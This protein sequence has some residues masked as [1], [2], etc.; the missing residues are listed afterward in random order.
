METKKQKIIKILKR[1]GIG[2]S[3]GFNFLFLLAFIIGSTSNKKQV[4][5]CL[6]ESDNFVEKVNNEL[7]KRYVSYN[8]ES[9]TITLSADELNDIV[10]S[11]FNTY[12]F[13]VYN[14]EDN[15]L[16][17][18][19]YLGYNYSV[20]VQTGD[21]GHYI[22]ESSYNGI[23]DNLY[24]ISFNSDGGGYYTD[25][26]FRYNG[27]IGEFSD[28]VI[29]TFRSS[30]YLNVKSAIQSDL[31]DSGD[32]SD[33]INDGIFETLTDSVGAFIGSIGSGITSM[34]AVF[35]DSAN[36]QLTT[37]GLLSVIVVA[38][39]LSYFLF[40]LIIGLIRMRG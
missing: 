19:S 6:A 7:P 28:S 39:S 10:F 27:S 9:Y 22:F 36:S 18:L 23:A 34:V 17:S 11:N 35:Y 14:S 20:S 30:Y 40:R 26:Y 21:E 37:I 31:G 4:N 5:C 24:P 15:V 8:D 29:F 38:V 3:I 1:I 13:S 12:A 32:S 33:S 25:D 2:L 16:V